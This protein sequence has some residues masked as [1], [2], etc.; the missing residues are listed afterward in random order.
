MS[1]FRSV[2]LVGMAALSVLVLVLPACSPSSDQEKGGVGSVIAGI[3]VD[4]A[5]AS[6]V[7][8]KEKGFMAKHGVTYDYKTFDTGVGGLT[9]CWRALQI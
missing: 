5:Y 8:A 7:V 1:Y 9:L 6:F 4:P 2:R 3:G